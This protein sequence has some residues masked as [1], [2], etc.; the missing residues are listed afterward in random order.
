MADRI[1]TY[2][3]PYAGLIWYHAISLRSPLVCPNVNC[4]FCITHLQKR[5]LHAGKCH[6]RTKRC[7][8]NTIENLY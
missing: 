2:W 4:T 8:M 1:V 6:L 5:G 7:L 3:W